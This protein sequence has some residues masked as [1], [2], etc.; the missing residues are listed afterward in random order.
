[1]LDHSLNSGIAVGHKAPEQMALVNT[2]CWV[3]EAGRPLAGA[4]T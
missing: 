2:F 4:L 1:M 3:A